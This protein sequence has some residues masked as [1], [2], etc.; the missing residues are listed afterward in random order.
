LFFGKSILLK[1][2]N[3]ST[4]TIICVEAAQVPHQNHCVK[5]CT[6]D[7]LQN[8]KSNFFF[9]KC[10]GLFIWYLWG[11]LYLVIIYFLKLFNYLS[12]KK[13]IADSVKPGMCV[14]GIGC[15]LVPSLSPNQGT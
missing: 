5:L 11:T 7:E 8:T 14:G 4:N 3:I 15:I 1:I 13:R 2:Y 12:K 10:L 6:L 9:E